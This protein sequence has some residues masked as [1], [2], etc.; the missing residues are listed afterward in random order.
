MRFDPYGAYPHATVEGLGQAPGPADDF[1]E[2]FFSYIYQVALTSN[3]VL[4]N[5]RIVVNGDA[6]FVIKALTRE[7]T[8]DFRIRLF[9]NEGR[10][11]SSSG[12]G[13]TNDRV[14]DDCLFGDGSLP[15]L[16]VPEIW[17]PPGGTIGFD[18]EDVSG[19]GNTV[20]LCF[21]GAKIYGKA[22]G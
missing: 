9:D 7:K 15:F 11:Y 12:E 22:G 20:H 16:V 8:G 6:P 3:Q 2:R 5:Q 4:L 18:L 14:R 13:G 10:Y 17:I 19:S 1:V 21:L